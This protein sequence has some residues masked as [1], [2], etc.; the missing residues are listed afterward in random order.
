METVNL[1]IDGIEVTVEKGITII[2][3]ARKVGIDIPSL[4]YDPRIEPYGACRLCFV[5]IDNYPKPVTAC[6]TEVS[7]GMVVRT[8][9]STLF[10]IRKTALELIL[11]NH[12][13]DCTAPCRN[14]CPAGID[15]QGFIAHIANGAYVEAAELIREDLPFPSSVGRICPKF[16]EKECRRQLVDE[17]VSICLLKRFAGDEALKNN[18]SHI[19]NILPDT[20]K[21]V[22]VVGGGPAG[23]T[24][25]YYLRRK[26]HRVVVFEAEQE[27]GGMMRY[28]IPQYRLPKEVL[29]KEIEH[30]LQLGIEAKCGMKMGRD[31]NPQSL[32]EQGFDAVFLSIGCQ[33][34]QRLSMEGIDKPGVYSGVEFLKSVA[35]GRDISLGEKV[36]VIGGGNTAM[37]VARTAVRMGAKEVIVVYR[38]TEKEMPAEPREVAEAKEEGVKFIFLASP[39]NIICDRKLEAVEC[40]RME[41]REPDASGRRRPVPIEGSEFSIEA[42]TVIMAVGQIMEAESLKGSPEIKISRWG[43]IEVEPETFRTSVEWVFAAGD[44]VTGPSTVVE[45]IGCGKKAALAVDKYLRGEAVIPEPKPYNCSKG[46]LEEIDPEEFKD[47][48]KKPRQKEAVLSVERR[49]TNFDEIVEGFTEK[50]AVKEA[51]RCL[52]CGCSEGFECRLRELASLYKVENNQLLNI[53]EYNPLLNDN[54]YIL[55]DPGKCI[56]CGSCVR[57]C[58]EV[59]GVGALGYVNRGL[60]TVIKPSLELPL[61]KTQCEFCGQCVSVCPTGALLI[62]VSMPKPGPWSVQKTASVCP[63]CSIACDIELNTTKY[64]V[65]K[66]T[67]PI[68]SEINRG[69]LCFKGAFG[70][71]VYNRFGKRLSDPLVK[72]NGSLVK[73]SWENAYKRAVWGLSRFIKDSE[74][75]NEI[76]CLISPKITNEDAFAALKLCRTVLKTDN[77]GILSPDSEGTKALIQSPNLSRFKDIGANDFILLLN[78]DPSLDYPVLGNILRRAV[79]D[80]KS[81]IGII[82]S[83]PTRFDNTAALTLHISPKKVFELLK[84]IKLISEFTKERDRDSLEDM[85]NILKRFLTKPEK[86]M[87]FAL[88]FIKAQNPLIL[89]DGKRISNA[90]MELIEAIAQKLNCNLQVLYPAV[91]YLGLMKLGIFETFNGRKIN[92]DIKKGK[93][94][95]LII[96]ADESGVPAECFENPDI[97]SVIV[98]PVYQKELE[99]AD[100]VFPG[101]MYPET[102]GSYINSEGRIRRFDRAFSPISGR[103]VWEIISSIAEKIN[104]GWDLNSYDDVLEQLKAILK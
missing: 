99:N 67:A 37:D 15:I 46:R 38:R 58:Q 78:I 14:A 18:N 76:A 97:F 61:S 59:Q 9:S 70:Y 13:G 4:C 103:E 79:R 89:C 11:S 43:L 100:V 28:G 34:E 94:K 31:F 50:Q 60:K 95:A 93:I 5:E 75:Q 51:E 86:I 1:T 55:R 40:I 91:N 2:E 36:V 63:H 47:I 12:Y 10:E 71:T 92:E 25:A 21:R 88:R 3:A 104:D 48:P 8:N 30:I 65:V 24:A 44:C 80:G 41:L 73:T 39:V 7:E 82:N 85:Q 16:C 87:S 54:E 23:L 19:L 98:T 77:I 56:L 102:R 33:A 52:S 68:D 57:I 62:K 74:P 81:E 66:V 42:D 96:I 49:I 26:G 72:V 64:G 35:Y 27:L 45:A 17:P 53:A 6:S 69:N 90:E 29:D 20:G 22:A 101:T 32:K 83:K 84:L